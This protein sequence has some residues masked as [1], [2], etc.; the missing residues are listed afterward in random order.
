MQAAIRCP[1]AHLAMLLLLR[2]T[3]AQPCPKRIPSQPQSHP[4][5]KTLK[6]AEVRLDQKLDDAI[7]K[8]DVVDQ[9]KSAARPQNDDRH[10]ARLEGAE[11]GGTPVI[12]NAARQWYD[13]CAHGSRHFS[14]SNDW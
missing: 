13:R 11:G 14:S 1:R 7:V 8:G 6:S 10:E 4:K 3:V 12:E 2:K 9:G 5:P